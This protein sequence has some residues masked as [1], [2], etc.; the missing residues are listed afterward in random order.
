MTLTLK[1]VRDFRVLG[2]LL[3]L[4][5]DYVAQNGKEFPIRAEVERLADAHWYA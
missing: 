3:A 1:R 2:V 4:A 5:D